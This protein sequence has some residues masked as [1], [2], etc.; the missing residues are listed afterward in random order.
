MARLAGLA[1]DGYVEARLCRGYAPTFTADG[2]GT[3]AWSGCREALTPSIP[4]RAGLA[5]LKKRW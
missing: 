3:D 5:S 1:V 4:R 2:S